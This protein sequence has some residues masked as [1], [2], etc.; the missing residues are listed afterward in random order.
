[1]GAALSALAGAGVPAA[2][3]EACGRCDF[4]W[5]RCRRLAQSA[6]DACRQDR[7][8]ACR[9]KCEATDDGHQP[10][11]NQDPVWLATC[12]RTCTGADDPCEGRFGR[13]AG[14]CTSIRAMC[15]QR[16]S[17]PD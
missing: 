7:A 5:M 14:R 11:L 10:A 15:R 13:D 12:V 2:A 6:Q 9:T 1:M 8:V 17:C 3:Q 16:S 4:D